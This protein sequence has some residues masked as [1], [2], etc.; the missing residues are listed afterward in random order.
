M[1][2]RTD[3]KEIRGLLKPLE[4]G[5]EKL[6]ERLDIN[7]AST[8]K[9]EQKINAALELRVDVKSVFNTSDHEAFC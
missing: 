9:I 8:M 1:L 2:T 7:T 3:L 4:N 5:Q 6:K